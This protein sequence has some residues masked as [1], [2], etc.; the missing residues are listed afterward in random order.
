MERATLLKIVQVF[1]FVASAVFIS[2]WGYAFYLDSQ[3]PTYPR[4]PDPATS[5]TTPYNWKGITI[6]L[7]KNEA[8]VLRVVHI[9][10]FGSIALGAASVIFL[11]IR[12]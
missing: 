5:R 8:S 4:A 12:R 2:A 9:T 11:K 1:F 7:S 6:Y 3:F 10:M